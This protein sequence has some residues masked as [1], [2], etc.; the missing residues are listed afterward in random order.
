MRKHLQCRSVMFTA[1]VMAL[2]LL[3]SGVLHAQNRVT[4]SLKNVT[5]EQAL[6]TVLKGTGY[7]ISFVSKDIQTIKNV[8]VEAKNEEPLTVIARCLGQH[9]LT[10]RMNNKTVVIYKK[11]LPSAADRVVKGKVLDK[12]K[13]PIVGA[14]I[15]LKTSPGIGAISNESGDFSLKVPAKDDSQELIISCVGYKEK[16]LSLG[17]E[18]FYPVTL[19]D[20]TIDIEEVLVTGFQNIKNH[21]NVGAFEKI[22]AKDLPIS[23]FQSTDQ[24]L[25]G[26]LSGVQVVSTSG[27]V[28][29]RQET[30]VR[31]TTTLFGNQ[32]PVWVVDGIIQEDPLPFSASEMDNTPSGEML[33]TFVG[34]AISWLNPNDIDEIIVL[35]DASATAL[36][37]VKAANGV[38]VINTKRGK[39]GEKAS[40][41]YS[42]NVGFSSKLSYDKMELMNSRERMGVSYEI[43]ERGLTSPA[44]TTAV[45][46]S[47]ALQMYENREYTY[48]QFNNRLRYLETLNTDWF[49][50]LF[51]NP[52]SHSHNIGISG[53]SD[54]VTYYS[55]IGYSM[56]KGTARGND[57][58]NFT[59]K[60]NISY[61]ISDKLQ[62]SASVNGSRS[63]TKS[64]FKDT[65]PYAYAA[66]TSRTIE[67]FDE[68]GDYL[69]Y[70]NRKG[71]LY[72]YLYELEHTGAKNI[73][74]NFNTNISLKYDIIEGLFVNT[75]FSM[76]IANV[77]GDSYADERSV[78]MTDQRGYEFNEYAKGDG[79]G[80]Y[81]MSK[82]P[83]GGVYYFDAMSM[84]NYSWKGQLSY[85]KTINK[86]TFT[87]LAGFHMTSA[88]GDGYG[89]EM[90]G[91]M[92]D[93]G[94]SFANLPQTTTS[95]TGVVDQNTMKRET[96]TKITDRVTNNIGLYA[97]FSYSFDNR[98]VFN[99]SVRSDASNKFG[100]DARNRFNPVWALGGRW[101]IADEKWMLSQKVINGLSLRFSY[102][103]QGNIS[104]NIGP[105]LV[106]KFGGGLFD[107]VTGY[108]ILELV[109]LP[110]TDLDWEKTQSM[111]VG[112]DF[113]LFNNNVR[114][115]ANM[116][117]KN[118][119]DL[120][121]SKTLPQEYGVESVAMNGGSL[122]NKGFDLSVSLSPVRTKDFLWSIGFNFSKNFNELKETTIQ[123]QTWQKAT[124]G[125]AN[126]EGYPVGAFW[127]FDYLGP[128]GES[129]YPL[130]N[131]DYPEE[132]DPKA[133]P[134]SFMKYM[135]QKDPTINSGFSTTF[136]Y[137]RLSLSAG[138]TIQLGGYKFLASPFK[139]SD[140]AP[141]EYNNLSKELVNRWTP[142]N[143]DS[144]IPGLPS[145][146]KTSNGLDLNIILPAQT[147]G[148]NRYDMYNAS[149]VR[150]ASAS[151]FKCN[152]LN[153]SYTLSENFVKS[154]HLSNV[155][156]TG[157]VTNP[158]R[159]KSKDFKGRDPEVATGGQPLS[160]MYNVSVNISF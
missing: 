118:T 92:P 113:N 108:K 148:T 99:G 153:I 138:F 4:V 27:L 8:S 60:T 106:T 49:D 11:A 31:G 24:M 38:I 44:V 48:D 147:N 104:E 15:T 73:Q 72:S 50:L 90:W 123:N 47:Q 43:Y 84:F 116:Y 69:R 12:S 146:G 71:D 128:D 117:Y 61:K 57:K 133:Y 144:N 33:R 19:E 41:T 120:I 70:K 149:S 124:S 39:Y 45:G 122:E 96:K 156:L 66:Q 3:Q 82:I 7:G 42:A 29:T 20:G 30:R 54:R 6:T 109:S 101:N 63:K 2:M 141:D 105:N 159:I 100:Q 98:F 103:Y 102:G 143:K 115:G 134:S 160:R 9:G 89:D 119:K 139:T 74:S 152:N 18:T 130:F 23:S 107:T 154:I 126:L 26:K 85:A 127:A 91:Y 37:G 65:A 14:T 58:D 32:E 51:T 125:A 111:N 55:S 142:Q 86:H 28:G 140:G 17:I 64:Y 151:M 131:L 121:V 112:L 77:L 150:V 155:S 132:S 137:K 88:K 87:A 40:I 136:K 80:M 158:F 16:F 56:T 5:L 21:E 34:N 59:V 52:V 157:S 1:I 110:C 53:G 67:A 68:N 75:D 35:K 13:K 22:S 81:E 36:Y 76:A 95:Q 93:M 114:V 46:F 25:Q 145:S 94:R 79:S 62:I 97:S 83:R 10:Y 129:G 135:G 78:F